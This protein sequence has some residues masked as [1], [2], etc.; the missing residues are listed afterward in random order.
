M[1]QFFFHV[2]QNKV[3]FEDTRG[4]EFV[5]VRAAWDWAIADARA[6]MEKGEISGRPDQSWLEICDQTGTLVASLPFVRVVQLH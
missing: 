5:D 3:L 1:P 2:R 4:G 6:M